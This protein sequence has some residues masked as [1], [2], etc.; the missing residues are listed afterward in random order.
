MKPPLEVPEELLDG[1]FALLV[2]MAHKP[3]ICSRCAYALSM[4]TDHDAPS[5]PV[6][7]EDE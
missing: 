5:S 2:S 4:F 1:T 7:D 3:E 6:D